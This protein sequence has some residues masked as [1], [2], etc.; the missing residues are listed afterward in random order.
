MTE[1]RWVFTPDG[2]ARWVDVA[3]AG[4]R[5]PVRCARC[6]E[7]YDLAFVDV[8][9]RYADCSVWR[10]PGCDSLVDD[11]G[12]TGWKSQQDYYRLGVRL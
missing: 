7:I 12:E 3:P 9:S 5:D 6:A 4:M 11:R 10:C 1:A 8:V 2:T